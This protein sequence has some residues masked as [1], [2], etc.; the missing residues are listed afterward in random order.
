MTS[1]NTDTNTSD[2]ALATPKRA[3]TGTRATRV[4]GVATIVMLVW[5]I[6]FGLGFSPADRDQEEAVRI[7]CE[8]LDA[9]DGHRAVV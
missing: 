9:L 8:L 6:A 4:I 5:L 7:M 3:G 2:S 1:T